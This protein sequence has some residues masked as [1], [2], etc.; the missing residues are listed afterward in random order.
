MV[1]A[2][3]IITTERLVLRRPALSDASDVFAYAHDAEVTRYMVWPTHAKIGES[4]AFLETCTLRWESGEEYCWAITVKPEDRMV[5]M[6]GCR[7]REYAADFGYVLNRMAWGHGYATEAACAVVTWL[8]SL[9]HIDRIWATCDAD[10]RASVRVLEKAGLV[11]EGCLRRSTIRP[12]LSPK[13]RD[14]FVF[15]L[16][17]DRE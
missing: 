9:P 16:V 4:L 1:H 5:G 12:N 3:E 2:P 15:A 13:P 11:Y 14:T 10:N 8:S 7:V 17:Q 6:I